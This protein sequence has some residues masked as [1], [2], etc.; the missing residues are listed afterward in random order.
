MKIQPINFNTFTPKQN[1]Y[2]KDRDIIVDSSGIEHDVFICHKPKTRR[3]F[4]GQGLLAE[5]KNVLLRANTIEKIAESKYKE[6]QN[7]YFYWQEEQPRVLTEKNSRKEFQASW[8]HLDYY[9][10]KN[11]DGFERIIKF[12]NGKPFDITEIVDNKK[13]IYEF[14]QEG[15]LL[16]HIRGKYQ[17]SSKKEIRDIKDEDFKFSIKGGLF[18]YRKNQREIKSFNK[19]QEPQGTYA[20]VDT[21]MRFDTEGKKPFLKHVSKGFILSSESGKSRIEE[22]FE[23]DKNGKL[24]NN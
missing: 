21:I 17:E 11:S 19:Y 4:E 3:E 1:I 5:G 12:Q 13:N 16:R 9:Y 14:S 2:F 24:I 22:Q 20:T 6:A 7:I 18:L 15:K 8:E 23:Y 10:E